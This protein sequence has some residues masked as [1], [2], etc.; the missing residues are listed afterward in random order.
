MLSLKKIE[1]NKQSIWNGKL[2]LLWIGSVFSSLSIS[3]YLTIEQWY[4]VD[5]LN[6]N[7][8]LGV[9][10]MATTIPRVLLIMLGGVFADR[11]RRSKI[12]FMSLFSRSLILIVMSILFINDHL[13]LWVLFACALLFGASD[14]FFWSARDSII[15]KI[16]SKEQLTKANSL[17]QTTNQITIML[18]PF[19]GAAL[20]SFFSYSIAFIIMAAILFLGSVII[21]FLREEK[22]KE[23][24]E[25]AIL[26][27]IKEGISYVKTS[28]F[29]LTV[30][31]TFIV[32][33]LFFVGPLM[34]S[35]PIMANENLGGKAVDLSILQSSFAGGMLLGAILMGVINV[36]KG[37]GKLVIFLV[38]LE[39]VLL[40]IFSQTE[41]VWIAS[42]VLLIIGVCVSSINIPIVS[43]I[44]ETTPLS[45]VGR[46][47]SINTMVSMG[48][49][50]IS[51]GV[52]SSLLSFHIS[53]KFILLSAG[54]V[55]L[56]FSI[57]L[58]I[59]ASEFKKV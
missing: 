9:I 11:Y 36:K 16:V 40:I 52:V 56:F 41:I 17:I 24:K 46:I 57:F 3:M 37:R 26:T 34:L 43:L 39:G 50:P 13:S 15:P 8:S 58:I 54:T 35:I 22:S 29:L 27:D 7:K 42:I 2:V 21:W 45:V 59:K 48:L 31:G 33:N 23:I 20:I 19:I 10:L 44:Q 55:V 30:M 14:A 38:A 47:M 32:V 25:S 12:I 1:Q 5:Y 53:I 28:K 4:V 51:Y 18:G 6:L 49:I